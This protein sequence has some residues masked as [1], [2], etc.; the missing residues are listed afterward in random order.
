MIKYGTW[1]AII[2]LGPGALAIFIWFLIDLIRIAK[3]DTLGSDDK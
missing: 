3:R 1:L 2:I